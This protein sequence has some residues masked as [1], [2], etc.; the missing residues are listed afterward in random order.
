[1][2]IS[3]TLYADLLRVKA[4]KK[5][6]VKFMRERGYSDTYI[7]QVLSKLRSNQLEVVGSVT[8]SQ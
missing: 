7:R 3:P 1:M 8:N 6:T 2:R 5:G 4:Q